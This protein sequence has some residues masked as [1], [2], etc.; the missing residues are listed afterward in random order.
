MNRPYIICHMVQSVDGKVT[1]RFLCAPESEA[2]VN[3]YYEINRDLKCNGFICGRV[4]MEGSF[5]CGY[6][7]DVSKCTEKTVGVDFIPG[8]LSGFYAVAFDPKGRL[9]W[10]EPFIQDDDPGYDKAQI[11][12]V[13][14]EQVDPRYL[15]YLQQ[16]GIPY[17]FAGEFEIDVEFALGKL[18]NIGMENLLLEGGSIIN[19][20]FQRAGV[21]DEISLVIS[22]VVADMKDKPLFMD[23]NTEKYILTNTENRNGV[24]ILNFRRSNYA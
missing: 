10:K 14:T 19:G 16:L 11:F 5:T 24:A 8:N 3:I 17:I 12:E 6:Y 1:G 22:P 15:G 20:A 21:I 4:T 13:L 9:G 23:G 7:P 2:A 18:K